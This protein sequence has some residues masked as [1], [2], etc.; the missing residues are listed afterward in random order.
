[1]LRS[2]RLATRGGL[3][4]IWCGCVMPLPYAAATSGGVHEQCGGASTHFVGVA[5][6]QPTLKHA[7]ECAVNKLIMSAA[8]T[9][10]GW[11]QLC[12]KKLHLNTVQRKASGT[13]GAGTGM[14]NAHSG[15]DW[16]MWLIVL[17]ITLQQLHWKISKVCAMLR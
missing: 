4:G 3:L 1:M 17:D 14:S 15:V 16:P 13:F 6:R 2:Q 9:T 12:T 10:Q 11:R 8:Q 7:V 5:S